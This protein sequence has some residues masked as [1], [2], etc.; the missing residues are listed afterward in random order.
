[1]CMACVDWYG[2]EM[3]RTYLDATM[4]GARQNMRVRIPSN[5]STYAVYNSTG[6]TGG[7]H[8]LETAMQ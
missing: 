6:L 5:Y 4:A 7:A 3:V 2:L 8:V 1:M